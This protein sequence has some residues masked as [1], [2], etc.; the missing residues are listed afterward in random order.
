MPLRP[1]H[2][3]GGILAA[4]LLAQLGLATQ[5]LTSLVASPDSI[6]VNTPTVITFTVAVA[7]DPS[8]IENSVTLVEAGQGGAPAVVLGT[9]YDDGTHGDKVAGDGIFTGQFSFNQ[10]IVGT[11]SVFASAAYANSLRRVDSPIISINVFQHRTNASI[12]TLVNTQRQAQAIFQRVQQQH[13]DAAA[14][15]ATISFLLGQTGVAGAGLGADGQTIWASYSDGL[16]GAILGSPVGTQGSL[17]K[18]GRNHI[19]PPVCNAAA[20]RLAAISGAETPFVW[21]PFYSTFA[22]NDAS[23]T[24]A[25]DLSGTCSGPVSAFL[26]ANATLGQLYMLNQYS[27]IHLNTHGGVLNGG[28]ILLTNDASTPSSQRVYEADLLS[29]KLVTCG[30]TF[31][32][33]PAFITAAAGTAGFPSSIVFASACETL[34]TNNTLNTTLSDAFLNHGATAFL[35]WTNS[36]TQTF[37][38]SAATRLYSVLTNMSLPASSRTILA[39]FTSLPSWVDPATNATIFLRGNNGRTLCVPPPPPIQTGAVSAQAT[40]NGQAWSGAASFTVGGPNGIAIEQSVPST[41]VNLALGSYTLK[42]LTGGPANS[43]FLTADVLPACT[44]TFPP[45]GSCTGQL[46]ANQSL[47]FTLEFIPNQGLQVGVPGDSASVFGQLSPVF[48]SAS[49]SKV[50]Y[51]QLYASSDFPGAINIS[52]VRFFGSGTITPAN[53]TIALAT[54]STPLGA[55]PIPDPVTSQTLF[56][57]YVDASN[58]FTFT[59]PTYHYNPAAGNLLLIITGENYSGINYVHVVGR[60]PATGGVGLFSYFYTNY[61]AD[62]STGSVGTPNGEGMSTEFLVLP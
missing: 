60:T 52:G 3:V 28:V 19:F 57:G 50:D 9:L 13:G 62:G 55:F 2:A 12:Q 34:G 38:A 47:M 42:Y 11:S 25:N 8:L 5:S 21:S 37:N 51:K 10:A 36:V 40:L 45:S 53:Y 54:V 33:M 32:I 27:V 20:V 16:Y 17:V 1:L 30:S 15:T 4:L 44:Q 41:T 26:D 46:S 59:G 43:V 35:G 39:A 49:I 61:Y 7:P 24:I 29:G 31:C 23:V 6:F 18:P 58:P 22:P 14:Q 48:S 56:S